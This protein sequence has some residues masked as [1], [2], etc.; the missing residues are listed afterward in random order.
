MRSGHRQ[1]I[2]IIITTAPFKVEGREVGCSTV[3]EVYM[4]RFMMSIWYGIQWVH[5]T[6][7]DGHMVRFM[8]II[9]YSI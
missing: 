7:Y 4:V 8:M 5:G 1:F 2:I 9:W 3:Y 6:V